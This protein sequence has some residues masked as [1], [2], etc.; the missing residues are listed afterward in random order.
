MTGTQKHYPKLSSLSKKGEATIMTYDESDKYFGKFK[1]FPLEYIKKL[2]KR[3]IS[4]GCNN[5]IVTKQG[6]GK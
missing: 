5:T 2:A 4:K 6:R 1:P 3:G